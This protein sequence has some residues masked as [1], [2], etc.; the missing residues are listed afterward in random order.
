MHLLLVFSFLVELAE[1][2]HNLIDQRHNG[3]QAKVMLAPSRLQECLNRSIFF[4]F[5][6]LA[7]TLLGGKDDNNLKY[8]QA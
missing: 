8:H 5:Y 4:Q 7:F 6:L 1:K 2:D 3:Y